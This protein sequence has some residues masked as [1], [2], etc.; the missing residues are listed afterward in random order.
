MAYVMERGEGSV[1]KLGLS[2][3]EAVAVVAR[4][5]LILT[6]LHARNVVHL[7]TQLDSFVAL[8]RA[9]V[10]GSLRLIDFGL[11]QPL[12]VA[13]DTDIDFKLLA[14]STSVLYR[15]VAVFREFGSSVV[16]DPRQSN[17][18][19]WIEKLSHADL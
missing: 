10:V 19:V 2:S 7:D 4:A 16:A 6:N 8:D 14:R 5:L 13:S 3:R 17:V 12:V 15:D 18:D 9:D 11:A 1:D